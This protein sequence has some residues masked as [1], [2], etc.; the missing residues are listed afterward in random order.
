MI[1]DHH[2]EILGP[3]P[4]DHLANKRVVSLVELANGVSVNR[5]GAVG[6]GR[7]SGVDVPPEHVLDPIG[8]VED[9]DERSAL[10]TVE[11]SKQHRSPLIVDV[12]GLAQKRRLARDPLVE[13]PRVL[14]QA[15]RRETTDAFREI[16]GVVRRM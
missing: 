11:C 2:Q 4:S 9:T 7:M 14:G 3:Q 16:C 5:I 8:R 10:E 12:V 6:S 13:G 1:R 15:Q